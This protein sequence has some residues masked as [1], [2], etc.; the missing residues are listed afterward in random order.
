MNI[1]YWIVWAHYLYFLHMRIRLTKLFTVIT[2]CHLVWNVCAWYVKF[3][4]LCLKQEDQLIEWMT[5]GQAMVLNMH[6][7]RYN[8]FVFRQWLPSSLEKTGPICLA[9]VGFTG[10]QAGRQADEIGM[11]CKIF[12]NLYKLNYSDSYFI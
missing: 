5:K 3:W 11:S 12:K 9:L 6:I 4:H 7:L 10:R 2:C 8:R 1:V